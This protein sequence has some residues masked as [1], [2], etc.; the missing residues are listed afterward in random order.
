MAIRS[1][2]YVKRLSIS[3]FTKYL[4]CFSYLLD[5]FTPEM[6]IQHVKCTTQYSSSPCIPEIMTHINHIARFS[7]SKI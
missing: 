2:L 1:N 6:G 4:A 5:D 7:Q 3:F